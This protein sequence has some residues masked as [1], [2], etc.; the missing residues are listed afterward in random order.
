MA[1]GIIPNPATDGQRHKHITGSLFKDL[2]HGQI[3]QGKITKS[4]DIEK[5]D[6]IGPFFKV[7]P[8]QGHRF[9]QIAH[10][11]RFAHIVLIPFG[12]HQISGII[13]AHI[14]AGHNAPG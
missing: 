7:T 5:G 11:T 4:G 3:T 12:H 9:S 1:I 10:L 2:Q 13:G 14:Q 8:C 6:L